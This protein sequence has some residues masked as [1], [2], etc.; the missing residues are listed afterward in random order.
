MIVYPMGQLLT[1]SNHKQLMSGDQM[2]M[3]GSAENTMTQDLPARTRDQIPVYHLSQELGNKLD[4]DTELFDPSQEVNSFS[5]KEPP[6]KGILQTL[7]R[8]A[9]DDLHFAGNVINFLTRS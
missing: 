8:S 9:K 1:N 3:S 2:I 7:I 6:P 5:Q 4:A